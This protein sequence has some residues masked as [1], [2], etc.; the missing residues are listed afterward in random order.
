MNDPVYAELVDV[1]YTINNHIL[2]NLATEGGLAAPLQYVGTCIENRDV[3][4][5]SKTS[6]SLFKK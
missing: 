2:T 4:H 3:S 5:T 6:V 1:L